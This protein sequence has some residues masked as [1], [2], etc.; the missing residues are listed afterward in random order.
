MQALSQGRRKPRDERRNL[1]SAADSEPADGGGYKGPAFGNPRKRLHRKPLP[2]RLFC[3]FF[4]EWPIRIQLAAHHAS[5]SPRLI[6]S[7]TADVRSTTSSLAKAREKYVLTVAAPT[8]K[9]VAI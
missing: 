6:A 3:V 4:I 7:T 2:P 8:P 5:I 9:A 1:L